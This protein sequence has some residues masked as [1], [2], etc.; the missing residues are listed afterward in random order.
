MAPPIEHL[1]GQRS[2]ARFLSPVILVV[3]VVSLALGDGFIIVIPIVGSLLLGVL[4]PWRV[5]VRDDGLE[6][7]FP[8]RRRVVLSKAE[9]TVWIMRGRR[10][11]SFLGDRPRPGRY[12]PLPVSPARCDIEAVLR[13]HGFRVITELPNLS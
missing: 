12:Y 3:S 7:R 2:Y 6:L 1:V 8:M 13:E 11:I 5:A 4:T 10:V 9:T